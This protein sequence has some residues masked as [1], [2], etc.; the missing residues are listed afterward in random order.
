MSIFLVHDEIVAKTVKT[1]HT[2]F[3]HKPRGHTITVRTLRR[4]VKLASVIDDSYA[5]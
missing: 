1:S 5:G 3:T 4:N 2:N